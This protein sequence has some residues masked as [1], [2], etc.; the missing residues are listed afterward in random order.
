MQQKKIF[1]YC[2]KITVALG[3]S[4]VISMGIVSQATAAPSASSP[5]AVKQVNSREKINIP[6]S[7]KP[8]GNYSMNKYSASRG[9]Q[10]LMTIDGISPGSGSFYTQEKVR[11]KWKNLSLLPKSKN[12]NGT[13]RV[14]II[15][16]KKSAGVVAEYRAHHPAS[17]SF[18][19]WSSASSKVSYQSVKTA[20]VDSYLTVGL[21]HT[22]P[23]R[24]N[25]NLSNVTV[26]NGA[27]RTAYLQAYNA[28]SKKWKN[29][30]STKLNKNY[31]ASG[32]LKI[33]AL[34]SQSTIKYRV[35]VPK[36]SIAS[37]DSSKTFTIKYIDPRK[38]TGHRK[39]VYNDIKKYCPNIIIESAKPN[40]SW[41][42]LA[43]LDEKRI[44]VVSTYTGSIRKYI[45]LHECAHIIQGTVYGQDYNGL[46]K[47]TDKVY[48]KG[49]GIEHSADCMAYKM[50]AKSTW[51]GYT[52]SCS[53][54][55]GT[56]ASKMLSGKRL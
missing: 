23:V 6:S 44:K 32:K 36:S 8:F 55:R 21:N 41:A 47:A 4:A 17:K 33:P 16:P 35:N 48:G 10:T 40:K 34:T 9:G 38:Y 50:G 24:T 3:L 19:A 31:Y 43:Y 7:W 30:T 51:A 5:T 1:R 45:S 11:G 13:F 18:N 15:L 42:G 2:A 39:L 27:G 20:I 53:G 49:K 54:K 56:A 37:A 28:K 52:K 14:K 46:T 29:I 22:W 26:E 12:S 25:Q